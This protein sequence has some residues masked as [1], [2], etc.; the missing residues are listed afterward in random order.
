M[1][2]SMKMPSLF[3]IL[4]TSAWLPAAGRG[5]SPQDTTQEAEVAFTIPDSTLVPEGIAHDPLSGAFFVSSTYQRKVVRVSPDG[6]ASDFVASGEDGLL[7]A[8]GM[9]VDPERRTLWVAS[10]HAGDGMPMVHPEVAPEGTS[11][12]HAYHVDTGELLARFVLPSGPE[13]AFL[14]DL[15]VDADGVA[16]VTDSRGSR[17]FRASLTAD[18]LTP[19]ADLAGVGQP[20]GIA[21]DE[22]GTLFVS[23]PDGIGRIDSRTGAAS[24][25]PADEGVAWNWADGIVWRDGG[26]LGI[27]PWEGYPVTWY[28]LDGAHTRVVSQRALLDSH[29]ALDQPTTAVIA[30]GALYLIANSHLQTFRRR[31]AG[32]SSGPMWEATVLRLRLD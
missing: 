19:F 27:Q 7:G 16:Y 3:M 22:S 18:A 23:V 21:L 6:G 9:K 15:V 25:L 28:A 14:N 10:S 8:V 11:A 17:I 1:V 24:L 26:I 5:Q 31:H 20:N 2:R 30:D 4:F 13:S 12:L 32:E 29:P